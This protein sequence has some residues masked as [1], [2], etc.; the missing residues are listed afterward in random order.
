[1]LLRTADSA[2]RHTDEA[3]YELYLRT[4]GIKADRLEGTEHHERMRMLKNGM[5]DDTVRF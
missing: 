3:V 1:M 4:C 5:A 2:C